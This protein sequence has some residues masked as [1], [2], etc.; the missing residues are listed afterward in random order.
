MAGQSLQASRFEYKYWVDENH[1]KQI[2]EFIS[3]YLEEDEFLEKFGGIGYPVCS[4][5]LDS[6]GLLLYGQTCQ[7]AKNR[8]KLRIRFYDDNP[9]NPAFLEIKARDSEV[10]KKQRAGVTREGA[11]RILAGESPQDEFLFG[12][13]IS[14]KAR[15][16]MYEFCRLRDVINAQGCTYVY[17]HRQAYVSPGNSSVRVT[18]DRQLE[19][20]IYLPGEPLKIPTESKQPK[21]EGVVLE[22]KFTDRRPNWMIELS[23]V[24]QLQRTSVPKY[25]MCVEELGIDRLPDRE[26]TL[27]DEKSSLFSDELK[28][29][30]K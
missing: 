16:A 18:F 26:Q 6:T 1:A 29:G 10:I 28:S 12:K 7:G 14:N 4:L 22:L 20:G 21:L 8:Y 3:T 2:R 25:V 27:F 15:K 19:G 5:Y 9:E 13:K 23:D 30:P 24:F 11:R 17:Y